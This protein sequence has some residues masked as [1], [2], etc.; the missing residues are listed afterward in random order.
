LSWRFGVVGAAIALVIGNAANVLA[1]LL[2]L[3]GEHR[4]VRVQA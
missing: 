1:M 4:R 3:R 2:Q